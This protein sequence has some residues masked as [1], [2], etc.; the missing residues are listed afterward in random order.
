MNNKIKILLCLF[1]IF[2]FPSCASANSRLYLVP[3]SGSYIIGNNFAV[4]VTVN[5]G[6][7]VIN[8]AEGDLTFDKTKFAVSSI[9]AS[10][11]TFSIWVEYPSFSNVDGT[12]SFSGGVPN[13]GFSGTESIFTINFM[14]IAL[15]SGDVS[16][17][18]GA[19]VL[20][21]DGIGTDTVVDTAGGTY[22][23]LPT[24]PAVSC[25]ALP[26]SANINQPITFTAIALGGIGVYTYS[27]S[28]ACAGSSPS[29][30][31]SYST[32][33]TKTA[34]I[35]ITTGSQTA[36][37]NCSAGIGLPGLNV[38][39]FS[40]AD[41]VDIN[42]PVTF[43][44]AASGGNGL[45]SYSWS[46][47]CTG[48]SSTCVNSYNSA[49]LKTA[50]VTVTSGGVSSSANCVFA[51]NAVCLPGSEV[52]L[53][54][55]C[56][57]DNKCVSAYGAGQ[58]QC[59]SDSECSPVPIITVPIPIETIKII[60]K[61]V[62]T[63]QASAA[64]KAISTTGAAV[65]TAQIASAIAFSPFEILLALAR[66]FGLFF[67]A[68]GL[69]KRIKPWGVVYDSV[70]K[71]PID[72]AYVVLKDLQGKTI[73]SA[74]TDLDGR[75]GFMAGPGV[76]QMSVNK[77]NYIFPSQK[78][79]GRPNDE[80]YNDLYFGESLEIKQNGDTIIKNIPMD[81][82]KFDWNEFAKKDKRL[83]K[84]YSRLDII[85]RQIFDLFFV[86]GFIAAII[87]Y[88]SAP[89]PY[90]LIILLIYLL[91]LFL[92]LIGI[93]PRTYGRITDGANGNPLSFALVRAVAPDTN[94]EIAH[95]V[96]DKYGKYYCL[97]PKGKYFVKIEKKNSDGSYFPAFISPVIDASKTG[98][99]KNNFRI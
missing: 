21:S 6:G 48:D 45:Y 61:A 71:Q 26:S 56:S 43:S 14:G 25:S 70:T 10:Q 74:I 78:L 8:T 87:A 91:L 59:Q 65:A 18:T 54:N 5:S 19:R 36:S 29:C 52:F 69:R 42:Q 40:S 31:N 88:F 97:V 82:L 80:F 2:A 22:T 4:S 13:P 12:I 47:A 33:G 94:V 84:F 50:T 15:G 66:L 7:A 41:S 58:N 20:L 38:S 9:D 92:R 60:E 98:I 77:T 79:L 67:A 90:N 83:M 85:L 32:P 53:R 72:P 49:G 27:W 99:I 63:P 17:N 44:A 96:A 93:K 57:L 24:V 76:Y 46:N 37:S 81:P 73:S 55:I 34:A 11:S 16:F 95:K 75:Y 30:T 68:I 89:Y 62:N 64:A 35:T 23:I 86:I 28:G 1:F 51:V 39:C 3:A